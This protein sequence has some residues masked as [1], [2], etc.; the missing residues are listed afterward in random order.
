MHDYYSVRLSYPSIF[1]SS[2]PRAQSDVNDELLVKGLTA[3]TISPHGSRSKLVTNARV[4]EPEPCLWGK[5]VLLA[6]TIRMARIA[7]PSP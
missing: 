4:T 6:D 5:H 3:L 2:K 7:V 1:S